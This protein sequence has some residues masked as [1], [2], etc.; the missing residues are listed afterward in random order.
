MASFFCLN[1]EPR[2][3]STRS[4]NAQSFVGCLWFFQRSGK[5]GN[6]GLPEALRLNYGGGGEEYNL[7]RRCSS[8]E[9]WT[10]FLEYDM[11]DQ[12]AVSEG[13]GEEWR[14]DMSQ[15][16][17]GN[18]FASGS[19]S[20]IYRGIYKQRAVA[21]K[22]GRVPE[23]DENTRV[24]LEKQFSSEVALLSR[25]FHPNI[26]E[27]IA[28]C[29]KPPVYCI[30]TEYMSQGTLRMFLH[31]KEPYSLPIEMI[32]RFALDISRG[33]LYL[34][35]QGVIHR[36]LKSD[37]LLLNDEMC[38]KVADFGTSCLE[39]QC[40]STKGFMGT[41]R[42]MAPEMI[43]EKPYTRKVD[44]YSFGIVLWE[45]ATALVP[46]QEMTPVQAAYAVSHK[47]ARP[48][49]PADCS[50]ALANLIRQCWSRNPAKRPDFSSIVSVLE[51]FDECQRQTK[52]LLSNTKGPN[53]YE[54]FR[55]FKSC[56]T[57][58]SSEPIHS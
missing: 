46:F 20:R 12:P 23:Q 5:K 30:I 51:R 1:S 11:G 2:R 9:S 3:T 42:W 38:V 17:I 37:N 28:A 53:S 50:P 8:V 13:A 57:S 35:S 4:S 21:V 29:K 48:Y 56:V 40:R 36:D 41:Y 52:S 58:S 43:K 54:L 31:K 39:T 7:D 44:V 22:L 15:L 26:V 45:L 18:K 34:H 47:N 49:L 6:V 19:H 27:F 24:L 16:F 55:N 10:M 32:L 14:A 33:M 25:L